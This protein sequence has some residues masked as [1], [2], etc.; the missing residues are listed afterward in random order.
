MLPFAVSRRLDSGGH[1]SQA[2]SGS[3]SD[4]TYT[5]LSADAP[6]FV[7]AAAAQKHP[8]AMANGLAT[9]SSL[10][11]EA[12]EFVSAAAARKPAVERK[13]A[14]LP[15]MDTLPRAAAPSLTAAQGRSGVKNDAGSIA[16]P[17]A[18]EWFRLSN[19]HKVLMP[20]ILK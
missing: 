5:I 9:R 8:P 12:P 13:A 18:G 14:D 7:S 19:R 10:R 11:K 1:S 4:S 20:T 15:V 2:E 17:A 6:P 16:D 3:S